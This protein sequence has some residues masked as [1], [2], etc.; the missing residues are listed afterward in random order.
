MNAPLS[1][2][3]PGKFTALVLAGRRGGEDPLAS[4]AGVSHKCLIPIMGVPMLTRVLRAL[5]NTRQIGLIGVSIDDPAAAAPALAQLSEEEA[6]R[7]RVIASA[8]TP[9]LSVAAAIDD[10]DQPPPLLV[11]TA[12]HPLLTPDLIDLFTAEAALSGADLGVGMA[13]A[14]DM[15]AAYPDA[16]RTWLRF[17]DDRY[18]GCNLFAL[19]TFE[20]RRVLEFWR[21]V[22]NDR[23]RPLRVIRAFGLFSLLAYVSGRL[24]L[25]QAMERASIRLGAEVRAIVLRWPDAAVDV[26]KPEDLALVE[27]ILTDRRMKSERT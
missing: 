6:A 27:Q 5:A 24:T 19:L 16:R 21:R 13:P 17:R 26:D 3:T 12:D 4:A 22:E 8:E 1:L 25:A 9:S 7:I 11:T 23:K 10:L 14:A 20:S 18:T 2:D 15:L